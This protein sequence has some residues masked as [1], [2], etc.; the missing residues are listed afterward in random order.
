MVQQQSINNKANI[1]KKDKE[2]APKH[3]ILHTLYASVCTFIYASLSRSII[4]I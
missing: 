3:N 4:I 2:H 1:N